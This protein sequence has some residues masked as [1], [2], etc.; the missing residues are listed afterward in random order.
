M[1]KYDL[2][3]STARHNTS[4]CQCLRSVVQH[5]MGRRGRDRMEL[6]LQLHM[7]SVPITTDVVSW[8]LDQGEV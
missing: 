4:I 2:F 3:F 7:Q 8:N 1:Q 6:D 5:L